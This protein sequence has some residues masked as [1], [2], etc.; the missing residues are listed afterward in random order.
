[1]QRKPVNIAILEYPGVL[2]SAV[3]GFEELFRLANGVAG[4]KRPAVE[5][6]PMIVKPDV[7]RPRAR[8]GAGGRAMP[9]FQVVILPPSLGSD[10]CETP[11]RVLGAWLVEQHEAGAVLC[12]VCAGAFLLAETGLLRNRRATTHW[13]LAASFAQRFPET[14]LD[15]DQILIDE[16]DLMTAGGLMAWIDLGL[17]I[18]ARWAG[19]ETM[20]D[21]ARRL[22][23]DSGRREQR[24]YQRFSPRLDHRDNVILQAQ[25]HLQSHFDEEV[26]MA[27]LAREGCLSER[28]FLRRF[29][30]ATGLKPVEYRQRLRIQKACELIEETDDS[31]EK[32]AGKVGYTEQSAFRKIFIRIC[33]LTPREFRRRFASHRDA[34]PKRTGRAIAKG[35]GDVHHTEVR[36]N[37]SAS[38]KHRRP[39][40]TAA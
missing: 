12:S 19:A 9:P 37:G 24:Y 27:A 40:R 32:I 35:G 23:I 2:R 26:P 17:E 6:F 13:G 29:V 7:I 25:R 30:R 20:R 1:M 39:G 4:E 8:G 3:F 18:V 5:F 16:G 34:P 14:R 33:G 36:Q 15:T 31:F 21:L 28:M 38:T 10:L 11:D 22:V